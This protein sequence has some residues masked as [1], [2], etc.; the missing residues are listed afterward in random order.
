MIEAPL[1]GS[2]WNE[3]MPENDKTAAYGSFR[4]I[5]VGRDEIRRLAAETIFGARIYASKD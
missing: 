1:S 4:N 3:K 5:C 2:D